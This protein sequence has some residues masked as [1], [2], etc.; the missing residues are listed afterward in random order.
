LACGRNALA[1]IQFQLA[2]CQ[3]PEETVIFRPIDNR[4]VEK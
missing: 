1:T 2:E 4:S 3:E